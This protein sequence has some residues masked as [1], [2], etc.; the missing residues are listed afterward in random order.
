MKMWDLL[1]AA[2]TQAGKRN[3]IFP[4]NKHRFL[5]LESTDVQDR[6]FQRILGPD[7]QS[8]SS[9]TCRH[10]RGTTTPSKLAHH[11]PVHPWRNVHLTFSQTQPEWNIGGAPCHY[12]SRYV[13]KNYRLVSCLLQ[14]KTTLPCSISLL[15]THNA[16]EYTEAL[17]KSWYNIGLCSL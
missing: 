13:P 10:R 14:S 16:H 15:D 7:R 8:R 3:S 6:K 17:Q 1:P 5:K 12:V 11:D 4:A 9:L 2:E